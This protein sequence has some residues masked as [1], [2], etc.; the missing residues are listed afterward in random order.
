MRYVQ[1]GEYDILVATTVIE[2][3][4]D[5]TERE[6]DRHRARGA[7]R[8][9]QLHQLRGRVGR[10]SDA[11]Y[12]LLVADWAQ[13]AE[14]KERLRVMTETRDGLRIAEADLAIRGPG[15][16]LGTRQAGVPDFRSRICCATPRS[17]RTRARAAEDVLRADP[18]LSRRER[19]TRAHAARALGGTPRPRA[20]GLRAVGRHRPGRWLP[21]VPSHCTAQCPPAAIMRNSQDVRGEKSDSAGSSFGTPRACRVPVRRPWPEKDAWKPGC[22][23]PWDRW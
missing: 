9:A 11:A 3:G 1:A 10:G 2:V 6:R 13:S 15:A 14:A 20:R 8:A 22:G 21:V 7:F 19:R 17:R 4:I 23:L 5:V 12:C 16:L 18:D